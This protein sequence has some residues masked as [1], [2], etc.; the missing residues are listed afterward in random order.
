MTEAAVA[1]IV[2]RIA[3]PGLP[4]EVRTFAGTLI[5]GGSARIAPA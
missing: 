1:M 4:P 3:A 5:A 2:E